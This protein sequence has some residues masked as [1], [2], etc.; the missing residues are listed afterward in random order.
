[1]RRNRVSKLLPRAAALLLLCTSAALPAERLFEG[2]EVLR[3]GIRTLWGIRR[4]DF[5]GDG[6]ADLIAYGRQGV[7]VLRNAGDG[8]LEPGR[9]LDSR[10]I[11]PGAVFNTGDFDADG[12]LDFFVTRS[13]GI[14]VLLGRGRDGFLAVETERPFFDS[15]RA[16]VADVDD[17]GLLDL[18]LADFFGHALVAF[19]DGQGSFAFQDAGGFATHYVEA[20]AGDFDGDGVVDIAAA[21][22]AG[23]DLV[24]GLGGRRFAPPEL[25]GTPAIHEMT[26]GDLD[27]DGLVDLAV[28]TLDGDVVFLENLGGVFASTTIARLADFDRLTSFLPCSLFLRTLDFDGDG[29]LDLLTLDGFRRDEGFRV[30]SGPFAGRVPEERRVSLGISFLDEFWPEN[31][32]AFIDLDGDGRLEAAIVLRGGPEVAI[33]RQATPGR[34]EAPW[35]V[36][37]GAGTDGLVDIAAVDTDRDGRSEL[38]VLTDHTRRS[39]LY[40]AR[41]DG[42]GGFAEPRSLGVQFRYPTALVTGDFD[43][44]GT[45]DA[46]VVDRSWDR[47]EPI[48]GRLVIRFLDR[49]AAV[50]GAREYEISAHIGATA[51]GDFDGDGVS[52]IVLSYSRT[53]ALF[54]G[55]MD[56]LRDN[57]PV[58]V[59]L[60]HSGAIAVADVDRD[61]RPD[62]VLGG[63]YG[64][65]VLF[66]DGRDQW[67]RSIELTDD[68]AFAAFHVTD[69]NLDGTPDLV[70][71]PFLRN[72]TPARAL[73]VVYSFAR[74]GPHRRHEFALSPG[75]FRG[76]A[77]AD[78]DGEGRPVALIQSF[79]TLSAIRIPEP[80]ETPEEQ[81]HALRPGNYSVHEGNYNLAIGDFDGD[82][83]L[84]CAASAG[85]HPIVTVLPGITRSPAFRRGD[86]DRNSVVNLSDAVRIAHYLFLGAVPPACPDSADTDDSGRL[87]VTDAV[88]L[89]HHLFRGGPVPP[90]PGPD[91]CGPDLTPDDLRSCRG[92]CE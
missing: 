58:V 57:P 60:A 5:D 56:P 69:V 87:T 49:K 92:R 38:L 12:R 30:F 66:N 68:G 85:W 32:P 11:G 75:V 7:A 91:S 55:P 1:M 2:P 73:R 25:F 78:L 4:A 64:I 35:S 26:A 79:S 10:E 62:L 39:T 33:Y 6:T 28:V 19:G 84:D 63:P 53:T 40:H 52:D 13:G 70:G 76:F 34:F 86:V 24:R 36:R 88:Y 72:F 77:V 48:D 51:S 46:A 8:T 67:T 81:F 71:V 41:S 21:H 59:R 74:D 27:A 65:R 82:G 61:G 90:P 14:D 37:T 54:Y 43:G 15:C 44:D 23:V 22:A 31:G 20:I 47:G 3:P 80:G 9:L 42:A 45:V 89:L 83:A 16:D 18:V 17:D 50:R 29:D